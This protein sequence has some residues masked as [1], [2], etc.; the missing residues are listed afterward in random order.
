MVCI[1]DDSDDQYLIKLAAEALKIPNELRF[2]SNGQS[3][4]DYLETDQEQPFLIL[5]DINMPQLNG[6]EL[7]KYINR[8]KYLREKSIP[9]V[10]L[11]TSADKETIRIAYQEGAQGFY[12]KANGF[13]EFQE[14]I[15]IIITYWQS[16]LHPNKPV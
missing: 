14:Q 11:T 7:R 10:F 12:Q 3:A 6:M 16:C 13:A 1:E 8:S 5:C 9:F 2:F 4:L 15:K